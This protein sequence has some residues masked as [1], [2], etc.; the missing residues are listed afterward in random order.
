MY[1]SNEFIENT[2]MFNKEGKAEIEFM[3]NGKPVKKLVSQITQ[4]DL[5][6][7]KTQ[8]EEEKTLKELAKEARTF[9]E[10]FNNTVNLFK[11]SLLPFID[12]INA[13]LLPSLDGFTM[14]MKQSKTIPKALINLQ[15]IQFNLI[16][17][18]YNW[19]INA[20]SKLPISKFSKNS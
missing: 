13:K 20:S 17:L 18:V 15:R 3:V 6:S 12:A 10:A 9:D 19:K 8:S 7:L 16:I 11:K 1:L 4:M 2:A 5:A 14:E